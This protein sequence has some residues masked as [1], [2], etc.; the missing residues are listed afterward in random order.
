MGTAS[1]ENPISGVIREQFPKVGPEACTLKLKF[2]SWEFGFFI[3]NGSC[4]KRANAHRLDIHHVVNPEVGEL[5]K[6]ILP[7]NRARPYQESREIG[8]VSAFSTREAVCITWLSLCG[9]GGSGNRTH[10][11]G[12]QQFMVLVPEVL[13]VFGF[14]ARLG[15]NFQPF[16]KLRWGCQFSQSRRTPRYRW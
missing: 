6:P 10:R 12:I 4:P 3:P 15:E 1:G 14:S 8:A 5:S 9:P 13:C 7:A 16:P 2:K 11:P